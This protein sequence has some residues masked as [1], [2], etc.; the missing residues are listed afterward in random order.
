MHVVYETVFDVFV[1]VDAKEINCIN[2]DVLNFEDAAK[3]LNQ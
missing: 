1:R 2:N 3:E